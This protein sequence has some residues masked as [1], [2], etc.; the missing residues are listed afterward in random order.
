MCESE[1]QC[2]FESAKSYSR[3]SWKQYG[4][5]KGFGG[6]GGMDVDDWIGNGV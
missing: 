1:C 6:A 5:V 3:N 4:I 2:K